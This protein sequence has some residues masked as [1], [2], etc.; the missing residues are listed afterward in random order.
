MPKETLKMM[1]TSRSGG[2]VVSC[3]VKIRSLRVRQYNLLR[4]RPE[5]TICPKVLKCRVW[6]EFRRSK[7]KCHA[8]KVFAI[9][10]S[11]PVWNIV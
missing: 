10:K 1:M 7:D 3:R 6:A 4:Q 11:N 5:I 9:F 8:M 2:S